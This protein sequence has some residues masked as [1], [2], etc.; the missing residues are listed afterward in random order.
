MQTARVQCISDVLCNN[1]SD[2]MLAEPLLSVYKMI[3]EMVK[4]FKFNVV[5][6]GELVVQD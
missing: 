5:K 3:R 1:L 6:D 2:Q 4:S